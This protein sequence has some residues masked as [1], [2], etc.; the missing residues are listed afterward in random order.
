[1]K[2]T[3]NI[4]KVNIVTLKKKEKNNFPGYPV[5]LPSEDIY[6]KIENKLI[7]IQRIFQNKRTNW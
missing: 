1:M 6:N 7:L 5:Y 4:P 3:I 2:K